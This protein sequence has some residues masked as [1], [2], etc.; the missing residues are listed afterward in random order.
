MTIAVQDLA[1]IDFSDLQQE[2]EQ[3]AGNPIIPS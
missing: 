3:V 2:R 1:N